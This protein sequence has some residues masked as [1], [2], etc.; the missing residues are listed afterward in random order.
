MQIDHELHLKVSV[1]FSGVECGEEDAVVGRELQCGKHHVL[2]VRLR[3]RGEA[4]SSGSPSNCVA[5]RYVCV[6]LCACDLYEMD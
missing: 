5:F 4:S 3:Q 2:L 1:V 6:Q